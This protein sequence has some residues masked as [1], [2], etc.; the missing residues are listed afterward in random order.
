MTSK[1]FSKNSQLPEDYNFIAGTTNSWDEMPEF[2]SILCESIVPKI[3]M[4]PPFQIGA[5]IASHTGP[6]TTGI[7]FVK[8]YDRL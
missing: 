5:T 4:L 8:K 6:E 3:N 1:Y 7:C 2:E